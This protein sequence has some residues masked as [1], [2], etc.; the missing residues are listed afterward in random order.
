MNCA[1]LKLIS[2]Y[3]DNELP[4][5]E[6]ELLDKHIFA[7]PACLQELKAI[8]S[9]KDRILKNNVAT[10]AEFFWQTLKKRINQETQT[11]SAKEILSLDF[12]AW[13]K[14]LIPV[15]IIA[16]IITAFILL[17]STK[18]N[19]ID[20]YLF[21]NQE[22]SVLELIDNAGSQSEQ[23]TLLYNQAPFARSQVIC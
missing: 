18:S 15:P 16:S 23:N 20:E 13:A 8:T 3:A 11:A 1:Y 4:Q 19:L 9:I 17:H 14:R 6:K 2:R 10:N 21:T 7:C 5:K 22:S 12:G